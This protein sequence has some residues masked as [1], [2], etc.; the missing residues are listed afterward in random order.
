MYKVYALR[1]RRMSGLQYLA[2]IN[3]LIPKGA[4]Q[5]SGCL[6]TMCA[7]YCFGKLHVHKGE[8][9]SCVNIDW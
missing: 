3:K 5:M 2:R 1:E 9:N 7:I 8:I 4:K 6:Q